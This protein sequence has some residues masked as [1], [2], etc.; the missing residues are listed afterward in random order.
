MG[1]ALVVLAAGQGTRM[2][3][4]LPKVMHKIGG[5]PLFVHALSSARELEPERSVLVTGHGAEVVEAAALVFDE[6]LTCVRQEPQLGTGHAVLAAR[7]ALA[8]FQG[9]VVVIYGD[10]PFLRPET[11]LALADAR[12]SADVVMLGFH[13]TPEARY[14]RFITLGDRLTKITEFKDATEAER[15]ITLCNAGVMCAP[16][17]PLFEMLGEVTPNNAQGEIYLTD[18][19]ELANTRGLRV[20]FITCEESETLGVDTRQALA[21]AEGLFQAGMRAQAMENGVTLLNPETVIFA[22]DT[23]LGRDCVVEA[24]VVFGPGVTVESGAVIRAFSH[25]EDAHVGAGAI[26]GPF[27][28]LR[29]GAV[30]GDEAHVGNFVEVKN[31]DIGTKAKVNHLSYIGDAE[32][33]EAT[34]IG[35][36]TITCN[37]DGVNKHRTVIGKNVFIGSDTM[38]VAPVT[39]GD[40]AMTASGSVVTKD[41]PPGDLAIGRAK[42]ENK[43]GYGAKLMDMLKAAKARKSKG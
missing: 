10:T 1:I 16:S 27:A 35:A 33:G 24:N 7:E 20:S 5:A 11:L 25:L 34:N 31:S 8:G 12:K 14:G 37:Y 23:A 32:I 4:D 43:P 26:V 22:Y 21:R 41:V 17:G 28:R 40:H 18:V 3:S 29:P 9:D 30:I 15:Q 6:G 38:L 42:Q 39:V 13:A 2:N 36:G 19:V